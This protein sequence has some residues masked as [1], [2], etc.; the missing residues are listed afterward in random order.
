MALFT[1]R[2]FINSIIRDG[3]FTEARQ[4]IQKGTASP[5]SHNFDE[6]S[7]W[8][9]ICEEILDTDHESEVYD[10]IYIELMNRGFSHEQID[11]MRKLAWRTAGWLNYDCMLWEWSHLDEKDMRKAVDL[12]YKR[13]FRKN[14]R[15]HD[16]QMIEHFLE[17]E[18]ES[19]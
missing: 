13:W 5:K 16:L 18:S 19:P 4:R 11:S 3:R 17:L 10:A 8:S 7:C 2:I 9:L 1:N 12:R 15:L 14:Q 6:Q